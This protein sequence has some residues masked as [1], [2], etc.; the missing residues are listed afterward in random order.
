MESGIYCF[1]NLVDNK[2]YIG[3]A[4]AIVERKKAHIQ[5]LKNN[6]PKENKYFLNAW[7]KYEKQN[8]KFWVIEECPIEL[9]NERE[10]Y[11]IKELHSHVTEHGYNL[12]WGGEAPMRGLKHSEETKK[13]IAEN[14]P[15][16]SGKNNPMFGKTGEECPSFGK[17]KTDKTK[18]LLSIAMK[19][20][21][22]GEKNPFYGKQHTEKAKQKISIANSGENHPMF[23]KHPSKETRQKMSAALNG[24]NH[25]NFGKT[26]PDETKNKMSI[27]HSGEKNYNFGKQMTE[28][29]KQKISNSQ[30]GEKSN[31]AKLKEIE[32]LEILNLFYNKNITRKEIVKKYNISYITICQIISGK[33]WKTT[34]KNFMKNKNIY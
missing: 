5:Q 26:L 9:L 15:D 30:S 27:S 1:E 31:N 18:R 16:I 28:E 10:I 21:Y 32:V 29:Q 17:Q 24:E 2:K 33:R 14:V 12:S 20:K 22:V 23:G 19:G 6:S 25:P 7:K 8:F 3:Q 11:W 34:Y 13:K 4:Q